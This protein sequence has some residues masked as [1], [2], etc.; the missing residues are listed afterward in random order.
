M[1]TSTGSVL[2]LCCSAECNVLLKCAP[3]TMKG[4]IHI[5]ASHGCGGICELLQKSSQKLRLL[6]WLQVRQRG[7][8]IP[9]SKGRVSAPCARLSAGASDRLCSFWGALGNLACGSGTLGTRPES[10]SRFGVRF[11]EIECALYHVRS[12]RLCPSGSCTDSVVQTCEMRYACTHE[13]IHLR[14]LG[15]YSSSWIIAFFSRPESSLT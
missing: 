4:T 6:H 7:S 10:A 12:H 5:Q 2:E 1:Q 13:T 15:V 8:C 14:S 3:A 11:A 9:S